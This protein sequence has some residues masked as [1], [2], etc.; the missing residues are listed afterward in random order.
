MKQLVI[1]LLIL[2]TLS[3]E[4]KKEAKGLMPELRIQ[5]TNEDEN[6]KKALQSEVLIS[7]TE[8]KAINSLT[9]IIKKRRGS[10]EEADL[11]YR[12]GELYMRRAKSGR[13][14]DL[15]RND[16]GLVS[17]APPEVTSE[18]AIKNL[19][20]A[21]SVY[22]KI[23]KDFPKFKNMDAALFNAAFASQQVGQSK[24]AGLLY[25]KMI[26]NYPKSALLPDSYLALGEL[27][28]L[29]QDFNS[30][31]SHFE[32]INRYPNSRVYPYGMYKSAWT[33]YNLQ[34]NEKAISKLID[35]VRYHDPKKLQNKSV[36][37]NLRG[38]AIR[39]LALFFGET[40][41]AD[42]AVSFFA[43]FTNEEELGDAIVN[44][45]K[46]YDS[47][48][49]HKEMNVFLK[50][51]VNKYPSAAQRVRAHIFMVEANE[52]MKNRKEVISQLQALQDVCAKDSVWTTSN[53]T[54][55][56]QSCNYDFAKVNMDI[57]KKWWDIWLKN[58]QHKEIAEL[59]QQ[60]F[61]I[62]L[63]LEDPKRPDS[64]SRY[65]YA[66][67]LFQLEDFRAA[68]EQYEM[69]GNRTTDTQLKH[70]S[71]YAALV[72]FEKA[73]AKQK[74]ALDSDRLMMLSKRY[75]ERNPKGE[76]LVQVR[77]KI[78]FV[79]YEA[80]QHEEAEKWLK[81]IAADEKAGDLKR[82]AEDLVLD[83][84]NDRKDFKSI[85]E[86][87]TLLS[88]QTK[89]EKRKTDLAKII[90]EADY[91]E[92]QEFA[93]TAEKPV[94]AERLYAF[95]KDH[96]G[97]SLGKDSLW[98]S[99][100]LFYSAGRSVD[101]ADVAREYA[102]LFPDEK[103][104][105]DALKDAAKAYTDTGHTL[106][107][108]QTMELIA[109]KNPAQA[110]TFLEAAAELYSLEGDRK[111]STQVLNKLIT[112]KNKASHGKI[113]AKILATMKGQENT[114]DYQKLEAK[115][116][117]LGQ[118]PY[119]S[120]LKLRRVQ[121]LFKAKKW[122]D[123]F[124]AARP[125]VSAERGA[126]DHVR[127]Q[128][129][130]IQAQV[131][132][133]E[134]IQQSTKTSLSKLSMILGLKTEKLS[135]AQ[136]AYV[137]SAKISNDPNV[138]LASF[139]GLQRIY[140]NYVET[141]GAPIVKTSMSEEDKKAL[142]EELAKL[143]GPIA[144]K[145]ADTNKK[146]LA[147]TKNSKV[148]RADEVDFLNLPIEESV[149]AR[150]QNPPVEKLAPFYPNYTENNTDVNYERFQLSKTDKCG[151][152]TEERHLPLSALSLKA[153]VCLSQGNLTE[154]E[155]IA[156][157]MSRNEPSMALG[158]FYFSLVAEAR[159][160]TEKA[161]WLIDL[162]L[163]KNSDYNFAQYQKARL[164]YK[165]QDFAA[166][167]KLFLKA[168]DY[169]ILAPEVHLMHGILSYA[170]GD[171][172]TVVEDFGRLDGKTLSNYGLGPAL[173]ECHAQKGDLDKGLSLLKSQLAINPSSPSNVEL[174]LETAYINE[175]Y[176]ADATATLQAYELALKA[177]KRADMKD[178]LHRKVAHLKGQKT[179]ISMV[180][181]Q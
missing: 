140:K 14:F 9:E 69:V 124:N 153:N 58:K 50:E 68:S 102:G 134:F 163:K 129:R 37:Y 44:L 167:N 168:Y 53:S 180:E 27:Q 23:E 121:E 106:L 2:T 41:T 26:S 25:S 48:S 70:D 91:T 100:S 114:A 34:Q 66:E 135:K 71:D 165:Q 147:L 145:M 127:A 6:Q 161:Q 84:Y 86:F 181:G 173:A 96:K 130:L 107:A 29:A 36:S 42:K 136:D 18:S 154:A 17:F 31:L 64:K 47:H 116:A 80:S 115:I 89:D 43:Q 112:D 175:T 24:Q 111:K 81:P 83:I 19:K 32:K 158:T 125:L 150:I 178:W 110:P 172:Y 152:K 21:I 33:Y 22:L 156:S 99:M 146:I 157:Q 15:V 40:H 67:L 39:D 148:A 45:A 30:A 52:S 95:Y 179:N 94:A 137:T 5:G 92:A 54:T 132:E 55:W 49:R 141:V 170:E 109:E 176:K 138:Q 174:H 133:D 162:S 139:Q 77:F 46:L 123:A 120:E 1:S 128:A 4:A 73:V 122:N 103:K 8:L 87:A 75:L 131:L 143:T 7:K 171:C 60:A 74:T 142:Q 101:G 79:A 16:K 149:K 108:A 38:E 119:F 144:E 117:A 78:G 159:K 88:S 104:S 20:Y 160:Q 105:L 59:T 93:K 166:A 76:H 51:Y 72:S 28:Y 35:V 62:H 169:K 56:D 57:A 164:L 113:Y 155:K 10:P 151:M 65:A 13:F 3:A 63:D 97:T 118:E 12:L 90:Q 177:A 11:W 85:K 98:Q 126:P 61:K 82:K